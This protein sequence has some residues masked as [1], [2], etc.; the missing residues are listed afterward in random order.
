[1]DDIF[2]DNDAACNFNNNI[3]GEYSELYLWLISRGYL[4]VSRH[5]LKEYNDSNNGSNVGCSILI[6]IAELTKHNRLN[7]I[8][9]NRINAFMRKPHFKHYNFTANYKDKKHVAT[10]MLSHRQYAISLDNRLV[11]D[12]NGFPRFQGVIDTAPS[13]VPYK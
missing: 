5:I 8:E 3:Q 6:I 4:A 11:S 10:I 2:I 9:D 7:R 13:G 1:M 12:V